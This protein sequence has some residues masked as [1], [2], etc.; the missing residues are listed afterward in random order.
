MRLCVIEISV[1]LNT[2][3]CTTIPKTQEGSVAHLTLDSVPAMLIPS[4]AG[5][6]GQHLLAARLKSVSPETLFQQTF[7]SKTFSPFL[8]L[9]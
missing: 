7:L 2:F 1:N 5:R 8:P 4:K 3:P 6:T 9:S